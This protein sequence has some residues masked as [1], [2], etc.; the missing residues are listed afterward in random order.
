MEV[1]IIKPMKEK[2]KEEEFIRPKKTVSFEAG[3]GNEGVE[4]SSIE[5]P[6]PQSLWWKDD[7]SM[8]QQFFCQI[9][10]AQESPKMGKSG[11]SRFIYPH[12]T[13]QGDPSEARNILDRLDV[14]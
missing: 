13:L 4:E 11:K 2:E 7:S 6:P 5:V 10:L 8:L 14:F 9:G 3:L 1:S 12:S